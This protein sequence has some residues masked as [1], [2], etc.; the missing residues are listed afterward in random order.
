VATLENIEL[1]DLGNKAR[2]YPSIDV[3]PA[4]GRVFVVYATYTDVANRADADVMLTS[5]PDGSSGSWTAPTRVNQD[6]GSSDQWNPWLDVAN[7][8]VHVCFYT[9][10]YD[11]GSI[12]FACSYGTATASPSLTETRVSSTS[13]PAATLPLGDYNGGFAGTDDVLHPA[14]GDARPGVTGDTDAYTARVDFSPPTAFTLSPLAPTS[15]VGTLVTFTATVTGAH[16]EPEQFIP[17]T[18]AVTG[19]GF[20]GPK[21]HESLRTGAA[22]T[23]GFSYTNSLPG[24]DTV[25]LFVDLDEDGVEDAN[26]TVETT[27]TWLPPAST[28]GARVS[29]DGKIS[30]IDGREAS[31][32]LTVQKKAGDALPKGN[33][34]YSAPGFAVVSTAITAVVVNGSD[35]TIFGNA[36]VNGGG[37]VAF[38]VDVVDGGE[39][40]GSDRFEIRLTG[41]YDS[42]LRPLTSGN[43]QTH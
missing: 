36:T 39:P 15:T 14:W 18:F 5:S 2:S 25:R 12:N 20:P 37:P 21:A 19:S 1:T 10:A 43:I 11:G 32:A 16:G 13:M 24:T 26:E 8:R 23:A 22:G 40:S 9:R 35:A 41:R 28:S 6:S 27:V 4:S 33:V 30:L 38:R 17:V 7:G 3:D 42:T 34:T 31:F 29:G